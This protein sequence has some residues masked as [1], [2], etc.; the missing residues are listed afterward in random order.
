M[1]AMPD[2]IFNFNT[3]MGLKINAFGVIKVK[4]LFTFITRTSW[5]SG[6]AEVNS[7][8]VPRL[9]TNFIVYRNTVESFMLLS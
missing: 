9:K 3:F 2:F 8:V 4:T 6:A 7:E 1:S 5:I